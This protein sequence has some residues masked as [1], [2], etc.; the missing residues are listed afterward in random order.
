[1]KRFTSDSVEERISDVFS[2]P[3]KLSLGTLQLYM[4][5][6]QELIIENY[7]TILKCE[8]SCVRLSY[9]VKGELYR[10]KDK[11]HHSGVKR[12]QCKQLIVTGDNLK[13]AYFTERN[14]KI[15]GWI[16]AISFE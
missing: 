14:M 6:D 10:G 12:K 11:V 7:K 2:L 15:I 13:I 3:P 5:S 8:S 4:C 1:M 16:E 9:L